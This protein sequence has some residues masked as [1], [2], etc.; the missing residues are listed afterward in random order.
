MLSG[1]GVSVVLSGGELLWRTRACKGGSE[2]GRKWASEKRKGNARGQIVLSGD[3]V[4]SECEE[5]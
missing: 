2:E 5:K 1:S 3:E 4:E